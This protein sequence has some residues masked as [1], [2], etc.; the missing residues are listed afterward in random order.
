M[1]FTF[2][3]TGTSVGVPMIG[4]DCDVCRS[5]DPRN[6]RRRSSLYLVAA[7][8]HLVIDTPPD[9]REQVLTF[10]VPRVDAVLFTHAHADHVFGFDDIRRF[11]TL[12]GGVIPAYAEAETLADLQRI[13][14]YISPEATPG[15]F[16]PLIE[17]R[18]CSETF[19]VGDIRIEPLVVDHDARA[20]LGYLIEADGKRLAYIPDCHRLPETT[21]ARLV[22]LDVMILDTLRR[23]PHPTHLTVTESVAY[24]KRIAARQSFCV[25]MCHDL[26]HDTLQAQ[27]PEGIT[28][29]CDGLRVEL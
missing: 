17:F 29:A 10:G 27:L 26:D 19:T 9:F 22:D 1:E 3:G 12:Q 6:R 2:L 8:T 16:R 24:L 28:V 7:G 20:T 13:F 21:L 5:P 23:R 25:H 14:R 15:V 4:C 18:A 11:N